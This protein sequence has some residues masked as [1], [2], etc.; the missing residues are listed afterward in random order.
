MPGAGQQRT[1]VES[2]KWQDGERGQEDD[3]EHAN[4]GDHVG[5]G[6]DFL[7]AQAG[8]KL[9]RLQR[10]ELRDAAQQPD[11]HERTEQY[12]NDLGRGMAHESF[13]VSAP[14]GQ[15]RPQAPSF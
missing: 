12:Q 3:H 5:Q 4:A 15:Q 7:R 14:L 11:Q 9:S 13:G 6:P 8:G 2:K 1:E 10:G